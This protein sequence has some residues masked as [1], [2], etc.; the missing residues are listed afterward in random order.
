MYPQDALCI[1]WQIIKGPKC[2]GDNDRGLSHVEGTKLDTNSVSI[3]GVQILQAQT[4]PL[5]HPLSPPGE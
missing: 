3:W 4:D 1:S 2:C 5:H